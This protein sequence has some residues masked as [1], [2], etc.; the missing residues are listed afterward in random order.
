MKQ[1]L[2]QSPVLA[3]ADIHKPY[4]VYT[5]ASQYAVRAILTQDGA[6]GHE[7]VISYLSR[8]LSSTQHKW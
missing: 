3:H 1:K 7:R 5:D 6:D 4:K 8:Y 2:T